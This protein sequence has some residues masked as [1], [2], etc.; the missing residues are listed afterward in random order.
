MREDDVSTGKR[1]PGGSGAFVTRALEWGWHCSPLG[2]HSSG[3]VAGVR[4]AQ[5]VIGEAGEAALKVGG[6][7]GM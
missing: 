3:Q 4:I 5:P 2:L 6:S 7:R 1:E